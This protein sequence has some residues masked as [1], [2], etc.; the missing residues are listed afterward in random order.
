MNEIKMNEVELSGLVH[1]N[2]NLVR[3]ANKMRS[4]MNNAHEA[5]LA[6]LAA[7]VPISEAHEETPTEYVLKAKYR[8]AYGC[9]L[10]LSRNH[11]CRLVVRSTTTI[12]PIFYSTIAV[13]VVPIEILGS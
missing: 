3:L 10:L 12:N 2:R 8:S 11:G 9:A 4:I 13:V 5:I 1:N 7:A 6:T